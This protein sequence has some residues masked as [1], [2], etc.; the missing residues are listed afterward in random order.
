MAFC[1]LQLN[2]GQSDC[3]SRRK[4]KQYWGL[5]VKLV[6][7]ILCATYSQ[8]FAC[9]GEE[10]TY[11]ARPVGSNLRPKRDTSSMAPDIHHPLKTP[12]CGR[13]DMFGE[14]MTL[15]LL[16]YPLEAIAWSRRWVQDVLSILQDPW[17]KATK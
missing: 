2:R 13:R 14:A 8:R 12:L 3:V 7:L 15:A 4:Y 10:K 17:R 1:I 6:T 11:Q 9:K 5:Q 16:V